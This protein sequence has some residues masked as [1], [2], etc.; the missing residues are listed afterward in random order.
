MLLLR[1]VATVAKRGARQRARDHGI[2]CLFNDE[3]NINKL[4]RKV[5]FDCEAS[6]CDSLKIITAFYSI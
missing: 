3:Q 4:M 2:S 1:V 6:N 5:F